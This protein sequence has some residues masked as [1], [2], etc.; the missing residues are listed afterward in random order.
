[1]LRGIGLSENE[2]WGDAVSSTWLCEEL[3]SELKKLYLGDTSSGNTSLA[4]LLETLLP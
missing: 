2:Q 4:F 1:M 3:L